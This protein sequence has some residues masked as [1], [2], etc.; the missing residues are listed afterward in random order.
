M[1]TT[2]KVADEKQRV[3]TATR[4]FMQ[5]VLTMIAWISYLFH[6]YILSPDCGP[7]EQCLR[8]TVFILNEIAEKSLLQTV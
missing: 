2:V 5:L 7:S 1:K 6:Y 4:D 3:S 8:A